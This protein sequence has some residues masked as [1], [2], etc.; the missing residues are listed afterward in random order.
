MSRQQRWHLL[1]PWW[2]AKNK[3]IGTRCI[4]P[5]PL[6]LRKTSKSVR[7]YICN[8]PGVGIE[9]AVARLVRI[10]GSDTLPGELKR[11]LPSPAVVVASWPECGPRI[12][13]LHPP[14]EPQASGGATP[15]PRQA[16]SGD[17]KVCLLIRACHLTGH[18]CH[19]FVTF[20][21]WESN[22]R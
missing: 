12:A 5:R 4:T 13:T 17:S 22:P 11:H 10:H 1:S 6:T 2:Q 15:N 20:P 19:H 9:P 3:S 8:V 16:L 7:L 21:G 18:R 14:F